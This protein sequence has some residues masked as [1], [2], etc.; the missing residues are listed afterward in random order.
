MKLKPEDIFKA[1]SVETRLKIIQLL[2]SKGPLGAKKI[3]ESLK[4]TTAAVS[5]H[6]KVLKQVGLVNSERKGYYIPYYINI[7][8]LEN[9]RCV[10]DEVCTCDC[11]NGKKHRKK[12]SESL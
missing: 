2:K 5:Q 4:I 7:D 6:L 12:S 8:T 9:C 10:I 3:A 11:K 1:L